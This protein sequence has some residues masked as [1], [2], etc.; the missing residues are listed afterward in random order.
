MAAE[1]RIRR[2]NA[3]ELANTAWALARADLSDALLFAVLAKA[4]ATAGL[5]DAEMFAVLAMAAERRTRQ[6]NA[7]GLANTA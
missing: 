5:S 1:R 4:F 7:Q 2:F 3:Q 6:F